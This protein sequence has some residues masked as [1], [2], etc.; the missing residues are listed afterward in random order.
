MNCI[1]QAWGRKEVEGT[2]LMDDQAAFNN[3]FAG[4][5]AERA[6]SQSRPFP[7]DD[8]FQDRPEGNVSVRWKRRGSA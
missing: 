3:T 8:T 6:G 1:E 5:K 4:K 7:M 2:L